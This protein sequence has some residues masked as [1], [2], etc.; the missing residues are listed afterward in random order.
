[1]RIGLIDI[2]IIEN[3]PLKI[4][5]V[6]LMKTAKYYE[7]NGWEVK[8][9]L[10]TDDIF[11][12]DKIIVFANKRVIPPKKK[13]ELIQHPNIE[14]Y[15]L[16][17]NNL[18]YQPIQ[19]EELNDC[20]IDTSYYKEL[21]KYLC[22][23]E[24]YSEKEIEKMINTKW[25][26]IFP[27]YNTSINI[28]K[29]FNGE[30]YKI[31]DT[32]IFINSNWEKVFLNLSLFNRNFS[33]SQDIVIRNSQDLNN[34]IKLINFGFTNLK[35]EI[36]IE[37]IN[38]YIDFLKKNQK[39]L[40]KYYTRMH[41]NLVFN[42]NNNYNEKFL[43]QRVEDMFKL[44]ETFNNL[45]IRILQTNYYPHSICNF[46]E[47]LLITLSLYGKTAENNQSNFHKFFMKR[48]RTSIESQ[49]HYKHFLNTRQQYYYWFSR[50]FKL[51]E[52]KED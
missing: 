16:I 19:S 34:F 11:C 43:E 28:G 18:H 27:F 29:L 48:N 52:I 49:V 31:V 41:Y 50:N 17:F 4:L 33:F 36:N 2:D 9:L 8:I 3:S 40:R 10:P 12:Y 23:K 51:K 24:M 35:A 5:N 30:K 39:I 14:Y 38:D 46:A 45:G 6:E 26:R 25:I 7:N 47:I 42:E 20:L 21:L 22:N 1:M 32:D 15:G 44:I 13:N 37:K